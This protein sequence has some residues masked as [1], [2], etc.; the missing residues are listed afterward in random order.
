[1]EKN[2]VQRNLPWVLCLFA[3]CAIII[4]RYVFRSFFDRFFSGDY[5]SDIVFVLATI[6]IFYLIWYYVDSCRLQGAKLYHQIGSDISSLFKWFFSVNGLFVLLV[7]AVIAVVVFII[8]RS[9]DKSFGGELQLISVTLTITLSALIPTMISRIVTRNQLNDII[10]QKLEAELIKYKTSLFNIRRDKGHASRMSAVLLEQ[11]SDFKGS[12]EETQTGQNNAAWSIGWASDAIIQYI[13]IRDVYSNALK[14]SAACLNIIYKAGHKIKS[15]SDG[16]IK[17]TIKPRDI[18]SLVTMHALLE[19]SGLKELLLEEAT[20]QAEQLEEKVN[21]QQEDDSTGDNTSPLLTSETNSLESDSLK[22]IEQAFYKKYLSQRG[23]KDIDFSNFCT[24][25]GMSAEF[26]EKLN[27]SA[28]GI[29][30]E[31]KN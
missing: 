30:K 2:S 9:S 4:S 3:G 24:I 7:S 20:K 8:V 15:D 22:K 1:M 12:P 28:A 10:E 17:S 26:N 19:Q 6:I 21:M 29:I 25:S 31:M 27:S 18:K 23:S 14:N 5:L 13:L 11:M 16:L